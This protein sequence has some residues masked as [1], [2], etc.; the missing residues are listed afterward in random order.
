[1]RVG[2][3]TEY[4]PMHGV[5]GYL[6]SYLVMGS[7]PMIKGGVSDSNVYY[8]RLSAIVT[9]CRNI[10]FLTTA[11][12]LPPSVQ[13]TFN[14]RLPLTATFSHYRLPSNQLFLTAL[15]LTASNFN[16]RLPLTAVGRNTPGGGKP[17]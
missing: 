14:Y 12:R 16:Y 1:M 11:Y 15:P 2:G 13:T 9:A 4:P 3:H 7:P 17:C 5:G 8:N 10:Y 6:S